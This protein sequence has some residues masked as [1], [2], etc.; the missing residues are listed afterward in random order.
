MNNMYKI[1][2]ITGTGPNEYFE[3]E[4][5][6]YYVDNSGRIMREIDNGDSIDC[7]ETIKACDIINHPEKIKRLLPPNSRQMTIL[8]FLDTMGYKYLYLSPAGTAIWVV[9][10]ITKYPFSP[11]NIAFNVKDDVGVELIALIRSKRISNNSYYPIDELLKEGR[12]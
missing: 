2:E 6:T 5:D 4:G 8:T 9:R 1:N 7:F 12:V 3:Y 10:V 11:P